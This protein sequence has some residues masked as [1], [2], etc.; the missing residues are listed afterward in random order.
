VATNPDFKDL[1]KIL[2]DYSVR[3]LIVGGYAVMYYAEP[4]FTKDIDIWVEPTRANAKK[5]WKTLA[6]FGAPLE[7][8]TED[9]FWNKD[10]VYQIGVAPNR[11]DIMMDIPAVQFN[12]AWK[13]RIKS[14]YG[15]IPIFIISLDDLIKAKE[16]AGRDQDLLDLKHLKAVKKRAQ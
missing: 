1:L 13:N 4:R 12:D 6:E 3:Y 5:I 7:Q 9:D 15:D 11:I 14:H 8:V 2:N 16:D 10:L